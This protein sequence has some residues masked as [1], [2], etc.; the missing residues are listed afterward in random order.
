VCLDGVI[1]NSREN[2]IVAYGPQTY[3]QSIPQHIQYW[4]GSE[5]LQNHVT[6][7]W[8]NT[9]ILILCLLIIKIYYDSRYPILSPL[10]S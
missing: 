3:Q 5:T 7:V 2:R 1:E 9:T 6:M 8:P 4:V 10:I